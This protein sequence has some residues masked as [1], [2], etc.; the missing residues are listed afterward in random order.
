MSTATDDDVPTGHERRNSLV[1][2]LNTSLSYFVAPVFYVG[3]LHAKLS[4]RRR[5]WLRVK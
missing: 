2:L 4:L 1:F 3:V 5:R